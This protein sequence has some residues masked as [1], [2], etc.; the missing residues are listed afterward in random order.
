MLL[1][2]MQIR[3]DREMVIILNGDPVTRYD[4]YNRDLM[5]NC[6][7]MN[8][9]TMPSGSYIKAAWRCRDY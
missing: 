6:L 3:A 7:V 4:D 5:F 9:H 2:W 1:T 8:C